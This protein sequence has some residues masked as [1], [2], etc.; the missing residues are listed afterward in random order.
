MKQHN[1]YMNLRKKKNTTNNKKSKAYTICKIHPRNFP[2]KL[3]SK[4][5]TDMSKS[6]CICTALIEHYQ[7]G[8]NF[9]TALHPQPHFGQP[10]LAAFYVTDLLAA[11]HSFSFHLHQTACI[12]GSP[13]FALLKWLCR[14]V[15]TIKLC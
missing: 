14:P 1:I 11:S 2:G 9:T 10:T 13:L 12:S 15:K 3:N 8:C 4:L 7:Q 5:N 6:C